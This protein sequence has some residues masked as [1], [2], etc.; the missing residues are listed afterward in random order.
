MTKFELKKKEENCGSSS[1][2]KIYKKYMVFD[3]N[4]CSHT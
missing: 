4:Q 1:I 3:D 2:L